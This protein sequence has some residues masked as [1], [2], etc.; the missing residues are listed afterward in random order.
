MICDVETFTQSPPGDFKC[1][2]TV[3]AIGYCINGR[4]VPP[5]LDYVKCYCVRHCYS[6]Q[7]ILLLLLLI[8]LLLLLLPLKPHPYPI[9][10]SCYRSHK[11]SYGN[12][13]PKIG[14]YGN[15]P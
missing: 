6:N 9:A 3:V 7:Y 1:N 8:L 13:S 5:Y 15:D 14:C 11:S 10:Y 2:S 4:V 12:F